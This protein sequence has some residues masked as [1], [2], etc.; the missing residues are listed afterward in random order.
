MYFLH[1]GIK[2]TFQW[3]FNPRSRYDKPVQ[4]LMTHVL[5]RKSNGQPRFIV[6]VT[7]I[8]I[9]LVWA[10]VVRAQSVQN[11]FQSLRNEQNLSQSSVRCILQDSRGFIW[12]GT[13]DGLN[14]FDGY[15][16]TIYR[17]DEEDPG[18]LSNNSIAALYEDKSGVIWVG[19]VGG[20]INRFN[21]ATES[22]TH[23]RND[24]ANPQSPASNYITL[25]SENTDGTLWFGTDRGLDLFDPRTEE[26]IHHPIPSPTPGGAVNSNIRW[27][28]GDEADTVMLWTNHFGL[29]KFDRSSGE[30][31][32]LIDNESDS[33]LLREFPVSAVYKD[34]TGIL[35]IG[36]EGE[37]IYSYNRQ[38]K[39]LISYRHDP[40]VPNSLAG[41]TVRAICEDASGSLWFG[42]D[43][44]LDLFDK[45]KRSFTHHR[46][47]P[48]K[49]DSISSDGILSLYA[50]KSGILW[51]GTDY[52]VNKLSLN[53]KNFITYTNDPAN[54]NSLDAAGIRSLYQDSAGILWIGTSGGGLRR[55]ERET[56][57]FKH[58]RHS[59][60][61][62]KSLSSDDVTAILEDRSGTLWFGTNGGGLNRL[63]R[64]SEN[65][66]RFLHDPDDPNSLSDNTVWT[67]LEDRN[68]TL[69]IGTAN[70]LD[71]LDSQ[72]SPFKH[73]RND[74]ADPQSL[75]Q[76]NIRALLEDASGALWV[77][78]RTG[79]L[80]KFENQSG[81]FKHYRHE[82]NNP[83]GLSS[84]AVYALYQ[85]AQG[86]LWAGTTDGLD[87]FD[88]ERQSF[89]H[90][91]EKDG[92]ANNTVYGILGDRDGD[93]W[94][95][96]N[97]GITRFNPQK[98]AFRSYDA[99]DGL[100]DDEFNGG[101]AFQGKDGEM[102]FGGIKGFTRFRPETVRDSSFQPPV[103]LTGFKKFD[104]KIKLGKSLDEIDELKLSYEDY[105]FSFEFAALDYTAPQKNQYAYKLEGFD[106]DWNYSGT[107]RV[108]IYTNLDGG[109]YVL[110]VKGTNSD[111]IWSGHE[112][113]IKIRI[114]PP[115]WKRWWFIA[116]VV[117][118]VLLVGIIS[119]R[120]RI[121]R[122]HKVRIAQEE[123]SRQLI[124]SQETERKRIAAELHDSLGQNLLII[125]NRALLGLI[126]AAPQTALIEQLGEISTTATQ[127][128]EEVREIARNLH[129]YK[130]DRLGLTKALKSI[131]VQAGDSSEIEFSA[132]I[133]QVDDAFSKQDEINLYR[134][135]Q[136]CVT[137]ILKH[138][139]ATEAGLIVRREPPG[140]HLEIRDN[141]IGFKSEMTD[142]DF[143]R[144]GFGLNGIAERARIIGGKYS[145]RSSPGN[146]TIITLK[147]E[148]RDNNYELRN[149]HPD[150]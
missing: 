29:Q 134:I 121:A 10:A 89:T 31:K 21:R 83:A 118:F 49:P 46:H 68:G 41:N 61:N 19:T 143:E 106:R 146:G 93:L 97:K 38:T 141:G 91:T 17:H 92:L 23:Y 102:F 32:D 50:D 105:V 25:I 5:N 3:I 139:Q 2:N 116:L 84:D 132:E 48:L 59:A 114:V 115:F 9:I 74:P 63:D 18:S 22:F 135:V 7:I 142:A 87:Q 15:S 66:T 65:F 99:G 144:R 111:G 112:A 52:R 53:N 100:Q 109:D 16:F 11:K 133:D 57:E 45:E 26:F 28:R 78:T 119:Y 149:T 71:V 72:T 104:Q 94:I 108:A 147:I 67:L 51:I 76:N 60:T 77:G 113:A 14:K 95:S 13:Q 35:R 55:Y 33:H 37:G 70:G 129:P 79:G 86:T 125:K 54:P 124:E 140:V 82:P 128:L 96:S 12:F 110:R 90:I 85:D 145:I 103:V 62:P 24:A 36:T 1:R 136:E 126:P 43:K 131:V 98:Q 120:R 58:Y 130:L 40:A 148:L 56:G 137:N 123:F 27:L 101:A 150:R 42:T 30:F 8:L 122:L 44:G 64:S 80:N 117:G 75:S 81:T 20:G 4:Q 69:W 127:A 138:S 88:F 34:M 73:Y 6:F 107:R 39:E 47:D